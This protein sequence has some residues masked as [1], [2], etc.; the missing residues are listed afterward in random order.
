MK[1]YIAGPIT[2]IPNYKAVF[3]SAEAHLASQGHTVI[4]PSFLPVGF[5]HDEYMSV[6]LPMVD[7]CEAVVMLPGWEDSKGAKTERKYAITQGKMILLYDKW[8]EYPRQEQAG[9]HPD[10]YENRGRYR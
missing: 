8:G 3:D 2:G 9:Q 10:H 6:C 5:E 7:I 4:N 1:V